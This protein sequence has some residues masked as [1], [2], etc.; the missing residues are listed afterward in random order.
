M[1]KIFLLIGALAFI[2]TAFTFRNTKQE[3][4]WK[5]PEKYEKLKNPVPADEASIASGKELYIY[6]CK[7]CHGLDGK[8]SGSRS[9]KLDRTPTDFTTDAFQSQSDGAILFKIY[10]G[11]SE[12]PAFKKK[13][14][15][16]TDA[17]EGT[18]GKTRI[19]GDLVNFVR[20]L[21]KQMNNTIHH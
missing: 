13:M 18:F 4:P 17:M 6:F 16:N 11:H 21:G 15:A 8:G 5:V 10:S 12:M 20:S 1:K 7:S 9:T 19:P 2:T 3:D 14:P